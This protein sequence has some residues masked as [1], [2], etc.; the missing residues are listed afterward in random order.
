MEAGLGRKPKDWQFPAAALS[1]GEQERILQILTG[2][3]FK[4]RR[5]R[6]WPSA[7]VTAGGVDTGEI[8]EKTMESKLVKGLFFAGEVID[9]DGDCGGF[10]L[11]WAWSSGYTAG[12]NAAI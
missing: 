5:T 11:Q 3:R 12:Q 10:N 6:S 9:I 7:Q 2:W 1:A 4:I 8:D